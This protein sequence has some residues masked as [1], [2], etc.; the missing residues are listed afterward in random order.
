[1]KL[2]EQLMQDFKTYLINKNTT[3]KNTIQMLRA[4]IL[5]KS[6]DLHRDLNEEE[7]LEII[8]KEIKQKQG[9][10][11]EFRKG[12]REDLVEQAQLEITTLEKYMPVPLSLEELKTIISETQS[13][14]NIYQMNGMGQLIKE[15]K[16]QTGIRADGK[17]ISQLVK[18]V[19]I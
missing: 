14:L 3:Q 1:M 19:L 18:E 5:N 15:V 10:I 12:N 11:D 9:A 6:K 2:S 13:E 8:A 17:T 16:A 7:I 4:E